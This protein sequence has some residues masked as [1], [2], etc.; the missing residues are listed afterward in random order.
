M[1]LLAWAAH[2]DQL[3][4]LEDSVKAAASGAVEQLF[5]AGLRTLLN[6][7][8][9]PHAQAKDFRKRVHAGLVTLTEQQ[10][11]RSLVPYRVSWWAHSSSC[12]RAF[13]VVP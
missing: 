7:L 11:V 4:A 12:T 5:F 8:Q 13:L 1:Q 2:Q 3:G 6:K 10:V 9:V